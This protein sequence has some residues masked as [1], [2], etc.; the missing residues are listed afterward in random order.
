MHIAITVR[1]GDP[2]EGGSAETTHCT[3]VFVAVS[4]TGASALV[5]PWIPVTPEDIM[6][7]NYAVKQM[8]LRPAME[9]ALDPPPR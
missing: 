2:R 1:A 4:S 9:R 5:H 6:L 8:E 7:K 3:M